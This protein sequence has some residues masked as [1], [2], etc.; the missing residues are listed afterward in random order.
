MHNANMEILTTDL[1]GYFN[2]LN[3]VLNDSKHLQGL[4]KVKDAKDKLYQ[5]K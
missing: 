2:I 1:N 3:D 5:V 4:T